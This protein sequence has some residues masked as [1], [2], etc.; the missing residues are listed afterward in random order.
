MNSPSVEEDHHDDN[1]NSSGFTLISH[2]VP[3]SKL[4]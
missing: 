4:F 3:L 2:I 1:H